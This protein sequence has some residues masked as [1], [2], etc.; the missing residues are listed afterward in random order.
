MLLTLLQLVTFLAGAPLP[1]DQE[2]EPPEE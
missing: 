1:G 2:E